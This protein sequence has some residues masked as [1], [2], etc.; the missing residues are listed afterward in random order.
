[1]RRRRLRKIAIAFPTGIPHLERALRG[2]KQYGQQRGWRF[3]MS[4]ETHW[5]RLSQLR[6][7]RGDGVICWVNT[8][9]EA[10][11]ARNLNLPIVN[12]S[13]AIADTGLPRVCVD[14]R[15]IGTMAA[16]HLIARGFEEL[17][18]YGLRNV[19]YAQMIGKGFQQAAAEAN[20]PCSIFQTASS[21]AAT[22]TLHQHQERLD[23]WLRT[24]KT[25][26]GVM[27]SHDERARMITEACFELGLRVPHDV[28]VIG[29]NNDEI[30][31]EFCEPSL[32][33][34]SRNAEL[35]GHEA[36]ALLDR[37]LAGEPAPNHDIIIPPDGV[38][39]RASTDITVSS[40]P[41]IAA[42]ID[43]IRRHIAEPFTIDEIVRELRVS[44]RWLQYRFQ[45]Q[46]HCSPRDYINKRRIQ[47]ARDLLIRHPQMRMS[48]VAQACGFR[49]VRRFREAFLRITGHTPQDHRTGAASR[50]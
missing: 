14:Y 23:R 44:R 46:M 21:F 31:C 3:V 10:E 1:M 19:W 50:S 6:H 40:D 24:L 30:V 47:H 27:A 42:A 15:R 48:D 43:Y 7:W 45:Q 32:T 11:S 38:I 12:L 29:M 18:Y 34:I 5:L 49:D 33:S 26:I 9:R 22:R 39:E 2:I 35:V 16:E 28:A 4:P 17:A 8:K 37:L 25:P 36:A 20:V 13:G 41:Q